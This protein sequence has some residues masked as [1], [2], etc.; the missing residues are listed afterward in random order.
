LPRVD[1]NEVYAMPL[2]SSKIFKVDISEDKVTALLSLNAGIAAQSAAN[3]DIIGQIAELKIPLTSEAKARIAEFAQALAENVIPEPVVIARGKPPEHDHNGFIEKLYEKKEPAT[4]EEGGKAKSFYDQTQIITVEMNQ[5]ILRVVPPT[6]GKDGIDIYGQKIARKL[7]RE[8]QISLGVNVERKGD[9]IV[10]GCAG[11]LDFSG[12][13]VAVFPK[14]EIAG[15]VDFAVGN[16]DFS[17]EVLIAKNVLDLFKVKSSSTITVQ[18]LVEAAEISAGQD[19]IVL[20]G[21]A[22]KEK[23]IFSAGQNLKSKYITNAKV[24]AGG[25]ITARVEIVNCELTCGGTVLVESGPLVGGTVISKGG[26][27]AKQLGSEAGVKTLLDVGFDAQLKQFCLEMAPEITLR[28]RKADKIRQTV[29][30]LMRN[31]KYLNPEQKEKAT[32]LLYQAEEL[33]DSVKEMIQKLRIKYEETLKTAVQE[34]QVAGT[35]YQGVTIRFPRVQT[36]IT[37]PLTGPLKII[38]REIHGLWRVLAIAGSTSSEHELKSGANADPFWETLHQIL[39]AD[40]LT[41]KQ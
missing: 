23:G 36:T 4:P 14:L 40:K 5:E 27:N 12:N 30:P 21:I 32:E 38:P 10:A 31:I 34:V 28:R 20:G 41:P 8:A 26:V 17:G 2:T 29:E 25:N 16:I 9:L 24:M 15:N 22:G 11:K 6:T 7:G 33:E 19:L 3:L 13:K 35:I 1:Q 18:G 37:E 39:F